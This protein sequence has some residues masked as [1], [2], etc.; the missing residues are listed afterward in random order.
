MDLG[1]DP[2][3]SISAGPTGDNMFQWQ[4]TIM[5]PVSTLLRHFIIVLTLVFCRVTPYTRVAYFS[6]QL[7]SRRIILSNLPKSALRQG[8]TTLISIPVVPCASAI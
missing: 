2:L 4:A 6:F 5:G 3:S 1:R 7:A 8:S